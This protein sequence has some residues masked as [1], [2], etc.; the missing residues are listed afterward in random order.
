MHNLKTHSIRSASVTKA[1][2]QFVP[3]DQI[4]KVAG[5]SN[6]KTFGTYYDKPVKADM[7]SFSEAVLKL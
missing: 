1:K 7:N 4:L 6:T 2:C 3:I 5:W